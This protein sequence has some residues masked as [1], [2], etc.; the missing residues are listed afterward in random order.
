MR[1]VI[2]SNVF[3]YDLIMLIAIASMFAIEVLYFIF[4]KKVEE[5]NN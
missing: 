5:R 3:L 2:D 4:S 1:K